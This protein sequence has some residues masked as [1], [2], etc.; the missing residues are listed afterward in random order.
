MLAAADAVILYVLAAQW[1]GV[2]IVQA[3][4]RVAEAVLMGAREVAIQTATAT[5]AEPGVFQIAALDA[6]RNVFL[7]AAGLAKQILREAEAG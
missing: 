7:P 5:A 2:A 1:H 6:R 4:V 3:D